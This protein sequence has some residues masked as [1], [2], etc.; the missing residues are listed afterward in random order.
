[1]YQMKYTDTNPHLFRP[2]I[3][4]NPKA[5]KVL[6]YLTSYAFPWWVY[7][8]P[9]A[10]FRRMGYEVVVYDFHDTL[11]DNDDPTV[12]PTTTRKLI[13][14]MADKQKQYEAR[15]IKTFHGI[16]NSLG[17]YLIFNYALRYPL[18]AVVLNGGGSI[19]DVI[20]HHRSGSW[21]RI[22]DRYTKKGYNRKKL[23]E[24]WAEFDLPT[25]GKNIKAEKILMTWSLK[26]GVIPRS[27]TEGFAAGIKASDKE[28]FQEIDNL[29]HILSVANNSFKVRKLYKFLNS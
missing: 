19:A 15:G 11:L 18:N 14:D 25:L 12:L 2:I 13:Q 29:P 17:S 5:D 28:M 6:F 24:L 16:G 27:S 1:M 22:A 20:F 23:Y 9:I 21:K 8:I 3:K 7:A 10:R 4:T 26:D